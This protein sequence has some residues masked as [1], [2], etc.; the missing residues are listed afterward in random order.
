LSPARVGTEIAR[1]AL[2]ALV[3]WITVQIGLLFVVHPEGIASVWPASGLALALL[4]LNPK[5]TWPRLLVVIFITNAAGNWVGGNSLPASL[6]FALAN[7]LEG[8]LSAWTLV[9]LC[10]TRL[11]FEYTWQVAALLI[12]AVAINGLT[13]LLGAAVSALL[14]GAPWL[15]AWKVWWVADGLG[16]LLVTPLLVTWAT[17]SNRLRFTSLRQ[18]A[19]GALL[20]STLAFFAWLLFGPFTT[21]ESPLLRNY[22]IFPFLIWLAFRFSP[23]GMTSGLLVTAVIAVWGTLQGY[24]IFGFSG[25]TASEHL[26]S[27]QAFL[28]VASLSGLLASAMVAEH[29]RSAEALRIA[30]TNYRAILEQAP[31]GF[32]QSTPEGRFLTVNPMMAQIFGFETP[33]AMLAGI[34]DIASQIHLNAAARDE[35]K[36]LLAEQGQVLEFVNQN[37]HQ[38]GSC[39]WTTTNARLVKD[40]T[41]KVLYYEGFLKD[42]TERKE[43]DQ[44]LQESERNIRVLFETMTE[45]VALNEIVYAENGEMVDYRIVNVNPAFYTTADYSG[46]QVIGNVA[47]RLYGMS[48]ELIK[49]FWQEHRVKNATAYTEMY[50]PLGR[51]WFFVA[52]SPFINDRFVT[53]FLD[54]TSQKEKEAQLVQASERLTLAQRSAGAGW[55]DW[56]LATGS[57]D[58]SPELFRMFGLDEAAPLTYEIWSGAIHPED[59][60]LVD[61]Q[62]QTAIREHLP[63]ANEYRIVLPSGATRWI[64]FLGNTVYT[65]TGEPRRMSGICLDITASKQAQAALRESE[66]RYRRLTEAITDYIYTVRV[67]QGRAVE[68]RHNAG[69]VAVTGYTDAEFAADPY[70]WYRMVLPEDR[71]LVKDRIRFLLAGQEAAPIEH[72]ITRKDG[73]MRW[74]RDTL[75]PHFNERDE[76][77]SYDGLI[78]D[79]TERKQV[80]EALRESDEQF[81]TLASLA[82][83]GIYLA[84]LEG[85]CL[86][87]NP[88]W[89]RMAGMSLEAA[90]GPGWLTGLHPDDRALVRAGWQRMVESSGQW[91]LEYRFLTPEGKVTTVYGLAAQQTDAS[92]RVT[93]YVG[94]NLD[95][96]ERKAAE[97]ALQKYAFIANTAPEFMTLINRQYVYESVNDAYCRA[98]GKPRS[99]LV[100]RSLMEV[101]GETLCRERLLPRF[102]QCFAGQVVS[103]EETF[104]FS[105]TE[106]RIYQVGMYPYAETPA[107]PVTHAVVVT[108]DI[109]ESKHAEAALRFSELNLRKA[110]HFAHVG[111][112][113]WNIQTNHLDWSDEMYNIFDVDRETFSGSL[114]DVISRSIHPDDRARVDASNQGVIREGRPTPLD[115]R[116]LRRDGSIRTV[117]AEAG[118]LVRD[119][120]GQPSLLSGTVQDITD[121]KQ[122][123]DALRASLA[124]KEVLLKEVHHRVKNNLQIV[125]SLLNMQSANSD[126]ELVTKALQESENRVR[127]MA[128]IH[129][130]LYRSQNLEYIQAGEYI[131]ELLDH[132]S[133]S[134]SVQMRAVVFEVQIADLT[135]DIGKAIPCGMIITELVSNALKYAFP[136]QGEGVIRVSLNARDGLVEL[137]VSDNGV[138]LPA[139][140]DFKHPETLGLELVSILSQQLKAKLEV[141]RQPGAAYVI[142]FEA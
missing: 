12:V 133:N 108:F 7:L 137:M 61:E 117:W 49:T 20:I 13:A 45:G 94:V 101:W 131:S 83:V 29:K 16:M 78:Q 129:E 79:I 130:K 44:A 23:R 30:E 114:P 40:Q 111:S 109:T 107:G 25:Q 128:L 92:G 141:T 89:C 1:L 26:V 120:A 63:L 134:F 52:T 50:S 15:A 60:P 36:H 34:T 42:I 22:M 14:L 21:A 8:A 69:C 10:K 93:R 35:F 102:E 106:M 122:I 98:R 24:G 73:A 87:A 86:Y 90:L 19:E 59:R 37:R 76:L 48:P 56:D 124:E 66:E 80:E 47:T 43:A 110:Q 64:S 31:V 135:F 77:V 104:L 126:N 32:F 113:T 105:G 41:G 125:S 84:D 88:A 85:N 142:T 95:I 51:K 62:I 9:Y 3:Y 5:R 54:I 75:S 55:W 82:P 46:S 103:Y 70:L 17:G 91:G 18:L 68:T 4:L 81:R 100:G 6:G 132:L 97:A 11:T 115:Y 140:V 99:E 112:W 2:V 27:V 123:E 74:I 72:R 118:E 67:E 38:D 96:T 138:G 71:R 136:C 39:I 57:L 116:I 127:A 53:S 139:E 28:C 33:A 58:W 121:R 119:A 65:E